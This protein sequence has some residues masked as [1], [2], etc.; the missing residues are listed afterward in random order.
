MIQGISEAP[1]TSR[2]RMAEPPASARRRDPEGSG[3]GEPSSF[4]G[5]DGTNITLN[6]GRIQ[7]NL[8]PLE[9]RDDRR[10]AISFAACSRSWRMST[11]ITLYM[12]PVQDLTVEDRVSRTQ[13]QYTLEDADA[14]R[15]GGLDARASSTSC[16]A[17]PELRDVASDHAEQGGLQTDLVIDRDTASRLGVTPQTSTT[18]ST[19][20]SASVR[21]RPSSR[22]S[23]STTWS[24]R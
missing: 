18:R 22:S 24:W 4:I 14:E 7:I 6:S 12:Q 2:S 10:H 20:P 21:S 17:L 13:Y 15:A 1:Q 23:T 3:G 8:K 11:G 19:T 16:E 5:V 9:Q